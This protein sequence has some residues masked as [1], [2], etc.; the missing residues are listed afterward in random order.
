ML[1][2]T[3][4]NWIRPVSRKQS[5][6]ALQVEWRTPCIISRSYSLESMWQAGWQLFSAK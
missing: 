3:Q 4:S 5:A 2:R 6:F 1:K